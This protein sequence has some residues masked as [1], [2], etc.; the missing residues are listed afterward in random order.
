MPSDNRPL[1]LVLTD[2]AQ[3]GATSADA[4]KKATNKKG[5]AKGK[6]LPKA[7]VIPARKSTRG[8]G[9]P[10]EFEQGLPTTKKGKGV[11]VDKETEDDE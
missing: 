7:V 3:Q 5:K 8:T 6:A 11:M 10:L 4:T 1:S 2:I 9:A